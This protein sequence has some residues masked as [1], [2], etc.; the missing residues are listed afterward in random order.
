MIRWTSIFTFSPKENRNNVERKETQEMMLNKMNV[1]KEKSEY[2][3]TTNYQ[4][5]K[6]EQIT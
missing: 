6:D 5:S 3:T 1:S 4:V 2:F